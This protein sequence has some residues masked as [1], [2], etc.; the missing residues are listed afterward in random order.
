[1]SFLAS[2]LPAALMFALFAAVVKAAAF[3]F[4]RSRVAWRHALVYTLVLI[5]GGVALRFALQALDISLALVPA[6]IFGLV[7]QVGLGSWYFAGRARTRA[8]APLGRQGAAI[9][10]AIIFVL[11]LAFTALMYGVSILLLLSHAD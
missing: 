5:V 7:L 1:M 6:A 10:S 4:R 3:L 8:G 2:L 11:L 9:L